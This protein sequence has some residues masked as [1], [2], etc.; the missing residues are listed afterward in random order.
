MAGRKI[1]PRTNVVRMLAARNIPCEILKYSA[2]KDHLDALSAARRLGLDPETV[3]KTLV[4]RDEKLELR[5]F[6]IPGSCELDL[7]KAA[8]AAGAKRIAL[9]RTQELLPLTGYLRG[10]CSP[11]GMK[12]QYPTYI[13]EFARAC[14]AI[15]VSAGER[16]LQV[17]L[18][19]GDLL[20]LT[21]ARF[22]D[23]V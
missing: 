6:C 20:E 12:R 9:I 22:A 23:L 18:A 5:V 14:A 7:K 4:A 21:A 11:I 17:R 8:R 1:F 3:F 16:G 10:G 2:D 15:T 19:P 13:D